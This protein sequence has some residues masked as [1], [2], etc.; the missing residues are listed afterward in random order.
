MSSS[1][2]L[3]SKK[4]GKPSGRLSPL[5]TA[6]FIVSTRT[7]R[8]NCKNSPT[9]ACPRPHLEPHLEGPPALRVKMTLTTNT[10]SGF[11]FFFV[12]KSVLGFEKGLGFSPQGII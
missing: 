1:C 3:E 4:T 10:F 12:S 6:C 9:G 2:P 8:R 11:F 5:G 7:L